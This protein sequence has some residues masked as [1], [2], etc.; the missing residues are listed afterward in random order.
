[1][2]TPMARDT[3]PEFPAREEVGQLRKDR[4]SRIHRPAPFGWQRWKDRSYDDRQLKSRT[5]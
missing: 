4:S 3:L 5:E 1:M 2:F